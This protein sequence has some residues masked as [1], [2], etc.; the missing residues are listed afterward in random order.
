M[1][2]L[3]CISK[4]PDTTAKVAFTENNTKFDEQGVQFIMNPFDEFYA[5]VRGVELK[6]ELGGNVTVLNVGPASNDVIIRKALAIGADQAV[7]IDKE[8]DSALR[9]CQ[10]NKRFSGE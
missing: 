1:E 3:V 10:T 4:T 6:E 7:R 5:L 9:R 8:P 2:I